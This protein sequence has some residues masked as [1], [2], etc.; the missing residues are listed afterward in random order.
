MNNKS[1]LGSLTFG[2]I[3]LA[4]LIGVLALLKDATEAQNDIAVDE[5][6]DSP[7]GI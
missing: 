3:V 6:N 1:M 7:I 5:I 2:A 4:G